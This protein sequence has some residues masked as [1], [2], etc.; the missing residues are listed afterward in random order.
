[1]P[2]YEEG[3]GVVSLNED[4]DAEHGV[5]KQYLGED[6]VSGNWYLVRVNGLDEQWHDSI[7]TTE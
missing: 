2:K 1:M 7:F 3:Q 5:I 6:A 4:G